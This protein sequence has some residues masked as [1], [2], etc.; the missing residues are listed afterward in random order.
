MALVT[1][2]LWGYT[3]LFKGQRR[4]NCRQREPQV[5]V[6][7]LLEQVRALKFLASFSSRASARACAALRAGTAGPQKH[8]WLRGPRKADFYRSVQRMQ[9]YRQGKRW[10]HFRLD[11]TEG[12][13]E[14][15][16]PVGGNR[17]ASRSVTSA[18]NGSKSAPCRYL[19]LQPRLGVQDY[20][21]S[22]AEAPTSYG[23]HYKTTMNHRFCI[24]KKDMGSYFRSIHYAHYPRGS[25]G[26]GFRYLKLSNKPK[27]DP[28][29]PQQDLIDTMRSVYL[30]VSGLYPSITGSDP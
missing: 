12:S 15:R 25:S 16:R 7:T 10:H 17:G 14:R 18:S 26:T 2:S 4:L 30:Q 29:R 24:L 6:A 1:C 28:N 8:K 13:P 22:I 19:I 11:R 20:D 5:V 9:Q 27:V 23:P 3:P 21:I